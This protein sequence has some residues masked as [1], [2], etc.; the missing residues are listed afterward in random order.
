MIFV[1]SMIISLEMEKRIGYMKAPVNSH[2]V[3]MEESWTG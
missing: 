3:S 1:G 2:L